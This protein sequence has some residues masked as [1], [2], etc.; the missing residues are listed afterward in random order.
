MIC[1]MST[2]KLD[3]DTKVNL[4]RLKEKPSETLNSVIQRLVMEK[5]SDDELSP[6]TMKNI[7]K[8]MADIKAGRTYTTKELNKKLGI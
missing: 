5:D 7:E 8:G 4:E 1:Y 2:I 3:E 6:E